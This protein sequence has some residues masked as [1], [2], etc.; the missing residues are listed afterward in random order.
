MP[1]PPWRRT[2]VSGSSPAGRRAKPQGAVGRQQW[3]RQFRRARRRPAAGGVAVE[4]QDRRRR[5]PPQL[6]ELFLGQRRAERRD[7]AAD[8][9]LCQ[10]DHVHVAFDHHQR[11]AR[12][13][14]P[15]A[16]DPAP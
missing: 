11:G 5:E 7:G 9:G 16:P 10:G 3:Q 12:R 15:P 1:S 8:A 14:P 6:L 13:A 2:R 4:A